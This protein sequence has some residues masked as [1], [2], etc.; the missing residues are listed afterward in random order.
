EPARRDDGGEQRVADTRAR[1]EGDEPM[2]QSSSLVSRPSSLRR[3]GKIIC[4]GRNYAAHAKELGNAIPDKPLLFLKPPSA[5]I[6]NGEAI[7]L[8]KASQQVEYEGEVGI[9][10]GARLSKVD[11]AGAAK[12][13]AGITCANDVTARDLQKTEPQ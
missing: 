8:P 5:V 3:P 12:G 4:V 6:E 10:I 1:L 13:I 9:V 11:E 7:V 2:K